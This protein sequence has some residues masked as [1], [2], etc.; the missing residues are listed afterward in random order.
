MGSLQAIALETMEKT[1]LVLLF[2]F[3]ILSNVLSASAK[4]V[5]ASAEE[6][7]DALESALKS[8]DTN[9]L[10]TLV[11]WRGVSTHI[12]T[13]M[14]GTF[15][16]MLYQEITDV[17][18]S[19]LTGNFKATNEVRGIRY[20]PNVTIVGMLDVEYAQKGNAMH[21][22]YGKLGNV[23]YISGTVEE[24]M[25]QGDGL[26]KTII[27]TNSGEY[28]IVSPDQQT[29]MLKDRFHK[30]IW[31]TNVVESLKKFEF[32]EEK[33]EREK[34]IANVEMLKGE[35]YVHMS[36]D[37]ATVNKRTGEVGYLGAN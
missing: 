36:K 3:G 35:I 7:R 22:P 2:G 8:K 34:R 26:F 13:M 18:L 32:P 6:L 5:S 11:N 29:L 15:A 24:K 21:L 14:D 27:D 12:K 20:R 28:V 33:T 4:D 37:V 17:K 10:S 1:I 23:F 16:D 30:I 25:A 19:P 31:S 9:A